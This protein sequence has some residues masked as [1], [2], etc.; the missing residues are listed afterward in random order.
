MKST[1]TMA[2]LS[3]ILLSAT[4]TSPVLA[5]THKPAKMTCDE[6]VMLD[7][8]VKPK[9]VY[10]AEGFNRKGKLVD[11]VV[12]IDATDKLVP[13]VVTECEKAPKATFWQTIKKHF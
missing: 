9:V 10:W 3:S 2:L 1:V 11:A 5:A 12:D 6:F 7:D 4:M 8:V 13:I